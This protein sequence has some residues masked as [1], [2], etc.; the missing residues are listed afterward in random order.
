M[1]TQEAIDFFHGAGPLAKAL[2]ITRQAVHDWGE[3]VPELRA[4]QLSQI[5]RGHLKPPPPPEYDP[6]AD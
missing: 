1:K 2:G 6:F 5:S 4:Y 3:T